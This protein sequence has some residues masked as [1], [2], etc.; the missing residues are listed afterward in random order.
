MDADDKMILVCFQEFGDLIGLTL[1]HNFTVAHARECQ[2]L[3]FIPPFPKID[4]SS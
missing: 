4:M 3:R 2:L 1:P